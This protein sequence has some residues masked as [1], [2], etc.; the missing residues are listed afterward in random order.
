M[1]AEC[2]LLYT[3]IIVVIIIIMKLCGHAGENIRDESIM[4]S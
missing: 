1:F 2:F 4:T 3:C